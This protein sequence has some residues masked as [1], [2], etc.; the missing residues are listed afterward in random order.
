MR[1]YKYR[2]NCCQEETNIE[3][4][5]AW[6]GHVASL[7]GDPI[8]GW[9]P[10]KQRGQFTGC[11]DEKLEKWRSLFLERAA[12]KSDES[13]ANKTP[14]GDESRHENRTEGGIDVEVWYS[15]R[16]DAAGGPTA[17]GFIHDLE[18]FSDD[19]VD[20]CFL[21]LRD[22]VRPAEPKQGKRSKHPYLSKKERCRNHFR[23]CVTG[24]IAAPYDADVFINGKDVHVR[25]GTLV[26]V[27]CKQ[28]CKVETKKLVRPMMNTRPKTLPRFTDSFTCYNSCHGLK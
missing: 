3:R 28:P 4:H 10:C 7:P 22:P 8:S 5:V 25:R 20:A 17:Q 15:Q 14:K 27:R 16:V 18:P 9:E 24:V 21:T 2:C 26:R 1:D 13:V 11:T 23:C 12:K 19:V 6:L